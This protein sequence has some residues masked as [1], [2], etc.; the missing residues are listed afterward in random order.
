MLTTTVSNDQ[1]AAAHA[2]RAA[3]ADVAFVFSEREPGTWVVGR[4]DPGAL[5]LPEDVF[6]PLVDRF[7]GD[8]GGHAGAGVAKVESAALD[9]VREATLSAVEAALDGTLTE[10]S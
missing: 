4:G 3:G 9:D 8:G 1:S 10:L 2:L 5:H 7:G 6:D